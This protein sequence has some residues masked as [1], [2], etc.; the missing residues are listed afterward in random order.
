MESKPLPVILRKFVFR[1]SISK[2]H[3][4][5]V[6]H[7]IDA[8]QD[9]AQVRLVQIGTPEGKR[10]SIPGYFVMSSAPP[11]IENGFSHLR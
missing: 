2:E 5:Y 7:D 1:K 8:G 6:D 9:T 4:A 10:A 11:N 3:D